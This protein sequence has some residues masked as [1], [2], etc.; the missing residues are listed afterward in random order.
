[1]SAAIGQGS[2]SQCLGGSASAGRRSSQQEAKCRHA[3]SALSR[4]SSAKKLVFC[5]YCSAGTS[6]PSSLVSPMWFKYS[7]G[8]DPLEA[9][10]Q[11]IWHMDRHSG[12][13][14]QQHSAQEC[15]PWRGQQSRA[16]NLA[17]CK[18][19]LGRSH[20]E[21]KLKAA[22][23]R[24]SRAARRSQ[25]CGGRGKCK[26]APQGFRPPQGGTGST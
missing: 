15:I 26:H 20:E 21:D 10:Q 22:P 12:W 23:G 24:R 16:S 1:M 4:A 7:A 18:S 19:P 3:A 13:Q 14:Q 2:G 6:D 9:Q 5:Q 11:C 25:R 17:P 8:R